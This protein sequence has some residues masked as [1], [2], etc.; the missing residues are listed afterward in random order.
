MKTQLN[1]FGLLSE[2]RETGHFTSISV[3]QEDVVDVTQDYRRSNAVKWGQAE[4]SSRR[5][6]AWM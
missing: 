3:R 1:T 6:T 5:K 4:A 2:V